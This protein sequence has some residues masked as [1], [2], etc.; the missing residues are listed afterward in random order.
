MREI[1]K[2]GSV[3][4]LIVTLGLLPQQKV[5]YGLYSTEKHF[6][7]DSESSVVDFLYKLR[8]VSFILPPIL[9]LPKHDLRLAHNILLRASARAGA[10][11]D[12]VIRMRHCHDLCAAQVIGIGMVDILEHPASAYLETF[13]AASA[14]VDIASHNK[15]GSPAPA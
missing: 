11:A 12:A 1:F 13:S 4:G 7:V 14:V 6:S 15:G 2:S 3:R 9:L 5:R 10:A 8:G